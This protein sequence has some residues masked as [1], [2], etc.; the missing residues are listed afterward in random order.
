VGPRAGLGDVEERKILP[1]PGLE[2]RPLGRPSH[3]QS[4]YRLRCLC[5]RARTHARTHTHS[6]A[7][8]VTQLIKPCSAML[9]VAVLCLVF[10]RGRGRALLFRCAS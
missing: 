10:K 8:V 1:M 5:S 9:R 2:P 3:S 4:L 7:V 6:A